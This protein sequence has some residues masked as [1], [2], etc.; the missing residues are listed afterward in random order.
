VNLSGLIDSNRRVTLPNLDITSNQDEDWF[1]VQAP[2]N[3]SGEMVITMQSKDLSS[4]S[5]RFMVYNSALQLV[6]WTVAPNAS[7]TFGATVSLKFTGVPAGTGIYIRA[8]GWNG[9]NSGVNGIGAY[10]LRADFSGGPIPSAIVAPPN[11]TVPER[12]D[13]GGGFINQ[14]I[15]SPDQARVPWSEVFAAPP[16]AL[17]RNVGIQGLVHHW[18]ARPNQEASYGVVEFVQ[19]TRAGMGHFARAALSGAAPLWFTQVV[20][21][22]VELD[23]GDQLVPGTAARRWQ[24]RMEGV[25]PFGLS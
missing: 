21:R 9:A 14:L 11:T 17:A 25:G 12:P 5:P 7:S 20:D 6:A 18:D 4:L 3:T 24:G 10:A 1:Y 16:A 19:P 2:S 23:D 22:V 13:Q 8:M 15:A